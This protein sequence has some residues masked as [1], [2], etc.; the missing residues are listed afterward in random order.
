LLNF[1][2]FQTKNPDL[3]EILS[4][5][6]SRIRT[7]VLI[8]EQLYRSKS[9]NVVSFGQYIM[10]LAKSI[11]TAFKK[12]GITMHS[13][14]S[15]CLL[16]IETALPLGLIVNEL[17]TNSYKY[18]FNKTGSGNIHILLDPVLNERE[19]ETQKWELIIEDDGVG[20]PESF[21][22][23][24]GFTTGSQMIQTLAD[25]IEARIHFSGDEGAS[26]RIIFPGPVHI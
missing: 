14:I 17:L 16:N 5:L 6:Q 18:A 1:Q 23:N 2:K 12:E 9:V 3:S 15:E 20:L 11:A 13:E 26:F 10:T 8:H 21:R 22:L 4:D 7:M 19:D 24:T 25:Q